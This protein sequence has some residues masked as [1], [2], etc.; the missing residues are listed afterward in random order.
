MWVVLRGAGVGESDVVLG[1]QVRK[2]VF[3]AANRSPESNLGVLDDL[4]AARHALAQLLGFR[5][6]AH[7]VTA[8]LLAGS[9][10]GV[11]T[12]LDHM[13]ASL[14]ARGEEERRVLVRSK[15]GAPVAAWD[16]PFYTGRAKAQAFHLDAGV[17]SSYFPL[18]R[19]VHGL[20]LL[21]RCLFQMDMRQVALG[22]GEGWAPDVCKYTLSHDGEVRVQSICGGKVQG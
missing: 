11:G 19:C 15:G 1:N 10:E 12:F 16:V 14:K 8:P 7:L 13:S 5:S 21:L 20:C 9:P 17:L 22:E 3:L 6:H 18:D 2:A 4:I